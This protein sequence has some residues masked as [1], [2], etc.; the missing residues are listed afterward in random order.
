MPF[1]FPFYR[2]RDAMDCGPACLMMA[3]AAHGRKYPL[4]FLRNQSYLTR[5]GVSAQGIMEAAEAIGFR[6]MTVKVPFAAGIQEASLLGA[7][8]PCIAHW[9]QQ[10]FVVVH[11]VNN[12]HVWVADPAV[13]KVKVPRADFEKSWVSDAKQGILILLEPTPAFYK[14]DATIAPESAQLWRILEYVRPWRSLIM[15]LFVGMV[16]GSLLALVLP[17]LTQS[18]VDF[19]I[20]TRNVRFI[21]LILI[22]QTTLFLSQIVVQ[23]LQNRILLFVGARVNVAMVNDFLSKLMRLPVGFFDTKMTVI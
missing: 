5:E 13:G 16:L 8:L 22:A 20:E 4:T 15:Q 3:A 11:K 7:P 18:I 19:G 2:Q 6:A 12:R 23:F 21:W 14:H 17:F 1:I 9:N 10:H